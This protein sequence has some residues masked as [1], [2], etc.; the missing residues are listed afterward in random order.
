MAFTIDKETMHTIV[1]GACVLAS[2]GGGSYQVAQKIIEEGVLDQDHVKVVDLDEIAKE[3]GAWLAASANMGAPD[4]LFKTTNPRAPTHAYQAMEQQ[5]LQLKAFNPRFAG[6]PESGFSWVLPIEV[7]AINSASPLTVAAQLGRSRP[8]FAVV[9]ADGAGRSIPT[10]SLTVFAA[11]GMPVSPAVVASESLNP[12]EQD[13]AAIRYNSGTIWVDDEVAAE[14]AIVGLVMSSPFGGIAGMSM[15]PF[16]AGD[17]LTRTPPVPGTLSLALRIGRLLESLTGRE[18]AEAVADCIRQEGRAS[19]VIW[20]GRVTKVV[21]SEGGV[22]VGRIELDDASGSGV[23]FTIYNENENVYAMRSDSAVPVVLGPDSISYVTAGRDP[24]AIDNSDMNRLY[25]EH[26]DT[27]LELFVLAIQAAPE[28]RNPVIIENF[29]SVN[30]S[31]G[32]GGAYH[33]WPP[34][35]V[36]E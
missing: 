17:L 11:N 26:P 10:L 33:P 12:S 28:M 24:L 31:L 9:D 3:P 20:H 21:Q 23:T 19:A 14:D 6:F 18:R 25:R 15:Y 5:L 27:R 30:R 32:Y 34:L 7:G 35:S 22:D 16:M 4:A 13:L 8:G 1:A 2:G 36:Q 29:A